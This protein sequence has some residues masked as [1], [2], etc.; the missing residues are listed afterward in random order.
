LLSGDRNI[1]G[2]TLNNGFLRILKTNT[3]AGWT[4]EMH[5]RAGNIG[6]ADGSVQQV[7]DRGLQQQLE[8]S[9]LP[10]IRLAIP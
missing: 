5:N 10:L 8:A 1:T 9:A 3:L 6:L 7:T 2:G 4:T